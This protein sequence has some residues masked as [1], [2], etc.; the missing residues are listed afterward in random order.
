[1]LEAEAKNLDRSMFLDGIAFGLEG[2]AAIS[3]KIQSERERKAVAKRPVPL[4]AETFAQTEMD[5]AL[6]CEQRLR[7][8]FSDPSHDKTSRSNATFAVR[9]MAV[10]QLKKTK[11][12]D[13]SITNEAF[14]RVCRSCIS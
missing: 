12:V 9:D 6:L 13:L 7:A 2:C 4:E 11:N 14:V 5:V 1:M 8:I 3:Q 10:K